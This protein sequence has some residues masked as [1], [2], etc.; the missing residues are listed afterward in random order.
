MSLEVEL[1]EKLS[2]AIHAKIEEEAASL[3]GFLETSWEIKF[4]K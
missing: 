1:F 3:G 4:S 2:K